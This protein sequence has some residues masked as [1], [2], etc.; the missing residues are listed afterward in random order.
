MTVQ[1]SVGFHNK[2]N[3]LSWSADIPPKRCQKIIE[4]WMRKT[5]NKKLIFRTFSFFI[6]F[7]GKMNCISSMNSLLSTRL[8]LSR[9]LS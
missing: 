8:S 7:H 5:K 1:L 6:V 2:I 3:E 4:P 9:Y